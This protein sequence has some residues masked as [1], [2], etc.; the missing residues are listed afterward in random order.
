M[1]I[2][3]ELIKREIILCGSDATGCQRG[4]CFTP[5]R[6]GNLCSN[7]KLI[8][9]QTAHAA[10]HSLAHTLLVHTEDANVE[11]K[12]IPRIDVRVETL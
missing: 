5:L 2:H 3:F 9:P 1:C 8:C 4:S 7:R 6:D 12:L 11:E 10:V